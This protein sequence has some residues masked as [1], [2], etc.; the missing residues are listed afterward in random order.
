MGDPG[1]FKQV[2]GLGERGCV[3]MTTAWGCWGREDRI[4]S[5][6]RNLGEMVGVLAETV[7]GQVIKERDLGDILQTPVPLHRTW[8]WIG[9]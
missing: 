5:D 7:L 3:T 6:C 1:G 8:G 2:G 9:S 4:K